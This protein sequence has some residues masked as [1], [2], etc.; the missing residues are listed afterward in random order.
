MSAH[1][2]QIELR[3]L[4]HVSEDRS[5]VDLLHRAG[6]GGDVFRLIASQLQGRPAEAITSESRDAAKVD[7]ASSHT[8]AKAAAAVT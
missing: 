7:C 2:G 6:P 8:L 3:V 1:Y 4:A 5:L